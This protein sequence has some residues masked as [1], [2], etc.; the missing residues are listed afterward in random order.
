MYKIMFVIGLCLSMY[1]CQAQ[2]TDSEKDILK[3]MEL[4]GSA[5][6]YDLAFDQIVAQFKMMKPNVPQLTWNMAKHDVFD[7]E[8]VELKKQLVPVYQK[9]FSPAEIKQLIEFYQ[10]PL[11]K[12]LTE[13]TGK[14]AKESM[15]IGQ[16][17]GMSLGTKLQGYLAEKGM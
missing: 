12:K 7:K 15:Q 5:A 17:W 10:S 9:N 14:I 11:G 1:V 4:N 2:Q 3:L 13:G 8:I 6:S 16:A